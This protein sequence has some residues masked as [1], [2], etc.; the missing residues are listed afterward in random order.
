MHEGLQ[1]E[2]Y[3]FLE[4]RIHELLDDDEVASIIADTNADEWCVD[5]WDFES[6]EK[7]DDGYSGVIAFN[8]SGE[9]KDDHMWCGTS[10]NGRAGFKVNARGDVEW[11]DV[12]A[13]LDEPDPDPPSDEPD[14]DPAYD[15]PDEDPS[16]ENL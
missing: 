14:Y 2:V 10:L 12:T 7:T 13:E 4:E 3:S 8:M 6:L 15:E 16:E 11:H 5:V 1:T 9:Q